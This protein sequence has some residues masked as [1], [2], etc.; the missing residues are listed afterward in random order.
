MRRTILALL[1]ISILLGGSTAANSQ[2]GRIAI[3]AKAGLNVSDI[4]SDGIDSN[5]KSGI[6]AGAFVKVSFGKFSIQPEVLY[7]MKGYDVDGADFTIEIDYF[8]FPLL[9]RYDFRHRNSVFPYLLLGPAVSRR[10]SSET[11]FGD[12]LVGWTEKTVYCVVGGG[13]FALET[14]LGLLGIEGRVTLGLSDTFD[15]DHIMVL[16]GERNI[17]FSLMGVWSFNP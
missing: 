3:G 11:S 15:E 17:N 4:I 6:I 8:E 16:D 13:G 2:L 7:S 10:Y 5:P 14:S 12:E 9:I 1:T